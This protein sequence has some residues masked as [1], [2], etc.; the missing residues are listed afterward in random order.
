MP[1]ADVSDNRLFFQDTGTVEH[2]RLPIVMSHGFFMDHEMFAPQ[3]AAL[4]ESYRTITWDE[5]GHGKTRCSGKPF[6]YWDSAR[7]CLGLLDHLGIES[8]VLV[9]MSQGGYLSLRA[10]LLAPDRVAGLVLIDT[11]ASVD[12]A[13][14]RA[15]YEALFEQWL[16]YGPTD[17]LVQTLAGL[18]INEPEENERWMAK[19]QRRYAGADAQRMRQS[20]RALLDREDITDRLDEIRCPSL[21]IHG[22]DDPAI[23]MDRAQELCLGLPSCAGVVPIEGAAHASNLTHP[24]PVNAALRD[25]LDDLH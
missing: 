17:E 21:V 13:E 2:R 12:D 22:T 23:G 25:F 24:S 10:A 18:I 8:A 7:D 9:G 15:Q 4:H 19:W 1:Y 11:Q 5:R 14:G 16:S 20:S 3:V 6:S